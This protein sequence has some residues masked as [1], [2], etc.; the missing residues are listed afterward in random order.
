MSFATGGGFENREYQRLR[1]ELLA[2]PRLRPRLPAFLNSCRDTGSFWSFIKPKFAHYEERRKY[3]R[4]EFEPILG[5]LEVETHDP[6]T[7]GVTEAISKLDSEAVA[8][9]WQK[10]LDRRSSD[11]EGAITAAR[12]LLESV[13][14][15]ILDA[16]GISYDERDDLPKLY[17]LTA[18]QLRLS[19]SQHTEQ[20]FKQVL[21]GCKSVVEGLGA[22]RNKLSD[23]HGKGKNAVKPSARHAE[24][25]VNLAGSMATFMVSTWEARSSTT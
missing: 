19:P 18:E 4:A 17:G 9:A 24:L 15:H 13:C 21:G 8:S 14:K 11:P 6:G 5:F 3:L 16:D 7:D 23:A 2:V 10:A 25:A 22:L 12:T 20:I 1:S